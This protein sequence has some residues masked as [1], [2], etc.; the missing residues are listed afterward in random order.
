MGMNK[1]SNAASPVATPFQRRELAN[2]IAS[3]ARAIADHTFTGVESAHVDRLLAN[4]QTLR[5][6]TPGPS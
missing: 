6:W 3:Q 2:V 4:V 5:A 1:D